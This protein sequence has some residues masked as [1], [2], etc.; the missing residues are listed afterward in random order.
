MGYGGR[1][2]EGGAAE[3]EQDAERGF[4]VVMVCRCGR[5]RACSACRRWRGTRTW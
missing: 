3:G 5:S 2:V 4:V 1:S